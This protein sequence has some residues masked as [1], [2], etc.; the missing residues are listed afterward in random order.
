ME[1]SKKEQATSI[2]ETKQKGHK[3]MMICQN[4]NLELS[5]WSIFAPDNKECKE[6]EEVS[7]QATAVLCASCTLRS[8]T[9][10]V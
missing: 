7:N 1:T 4:S 5:K 2:W 8:V 9:D 10:I 6:W 3:R